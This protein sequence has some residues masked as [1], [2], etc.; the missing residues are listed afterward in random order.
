MLHR[1]KSIEHNVKLSALIYTV[2]N[3][4]GLIFSFAARGSAFKSLRI[5]TGRELFFKRTRRAS[6][7]M[8]A[9]RATL[10]TRLFY[11][12]KIRPCP[13]DGP[14]RNTNSS[15]FKGINSRG[16]FYY[17]H[18]YGTEFNYYSTRISM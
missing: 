15:V 10:C 14:A 4:F 11:I 7:C 13:D 12:L 6:G 1:Q 18:N 17:Y 2:N 5:A 9:R 3:D 16:I 8:H